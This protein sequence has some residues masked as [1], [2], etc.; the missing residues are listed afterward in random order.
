MF[1]GN[2]ISWVL[3]MMNSNFKNRCFA[4]TILLFNKFAV[5]ILTLTCFLNKVLYT[6]WVLIIKAF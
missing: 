1:L 3:N 5:E 2:Q 6:V 4:V